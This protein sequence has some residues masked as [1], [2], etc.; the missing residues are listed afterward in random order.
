MAV[1]WLFK[2][3]PQLNNPVVI[4]FAFAIILLIVYYLLK[5]GGG[6]L[7]Q[8]MKVFYFADVERLVSPL[9]VTKLTP[10]SVITDDKKFWRRAKSWL[11][12]KGNR[13]FVVFLGKVGSGITYSLERNSKDDDG[14]AQLEKLGSLYD[15][16]IR[17]LNVKEDNELTPQTFTPES[18]ELLKKSEIF[19]CVDLEIDPDDLP[20][21]FNEDNAVN[22]A[23]KAF[24]SLVG[25]QIR[26]K[27][28]QEDWIRNV[29]LMAMGATALW[30]GQSLGF[31]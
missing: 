10:S 2:L 3:Y 6:D 17:C 8:D 12:K 23:D 31:F 28:A 13:T 24:S 11:W 20:A 21:D 18:L 29:G 16:L 1:F 14:K 30:L 9:E 19:V 15:G 22:D 27:L 26:N 4:I 7:H 5:K 25:E